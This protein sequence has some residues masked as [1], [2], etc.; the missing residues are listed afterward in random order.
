LNELNIHILV[1][2]L[3]QFPSESYRVAEILK[4][5]DFRKLSSPPLIRQTA[6]PK[7]QLSTSYR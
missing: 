1:V 5:I 7:P 4:L 2:S 6:S 3:S